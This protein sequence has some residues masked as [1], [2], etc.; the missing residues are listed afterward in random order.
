MIDES[1]CTYCGKCYDYCNYNAIFFLG[2][3]RMIRVMED[4]CHGCGACSVACEFG[5]IT[6]KEDL[7]GTVSQYSILVSH[8]IEARMKVGVHSPV[9]L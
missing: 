3:Q 2:E 4:L 5:A 7:L 9:G 8:A 1:K 6:E